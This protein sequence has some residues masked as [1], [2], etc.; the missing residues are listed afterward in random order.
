[1]TTYSKTNPFLATI[2]ER[3]SLCTPHSQKDTQHVVL[4]LQGSN[5]NYEV[6]DSV[7][8]CPKNNPI[9]VQRTLEALKAT[10]SEIV[11]DRDQK[12]WKLADLLATHVNINEINQKFVT[13]LCQHL[14][15]TKNPFDTLLQEENRKHLKEFLLSHSYWQLLKQYPEVTF[16]PQALVNL[17]TPLLPRFYSIASAQSVVG[18]EMH[19]TVALLKYLIADQERLGVCTNYLCHLAPMQQPIVPLYIHPHR[20]FTLPN[21]PDHSIIMI[22]PGTGVAPFRAFMQERI[23]QR[24]KGKNWLFFGEWNRH[25][26]FFYESY[27]N[28]LVIKGQLRLDVAFSRDQQHKIYVQHRMLEKG[29]DLFRWLEEGAY[30]YVCGDAEHM[31]KDV[32]AALL[33][34]IQQHGALDLQEARNYLKR[35]RNE[36]RY[37]RDVY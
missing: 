14:D 30:L 32:E 34:I 31:A 8:I 36:K 15:S 28:D 35:L 3:Y 20:G 4:C 7:A 26:N 23:N 22:G 29:A 27:W 21:N 37:L 24:A 19:L 6:G 13:A 9:T 2:K 25:S 10:G 12:E 17:L 16:T 1:M 33:A 5:I 11:K 18:N